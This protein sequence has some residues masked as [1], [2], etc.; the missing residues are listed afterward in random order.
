[1][2][3]LKFDKYIYRE[4][5]I[6]LDIYLF[7]SQ[8]PYSSQGHG[9]TEADQADPLQAQRCSVGTAAPSILTQTPQKK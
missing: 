4:M 1:M 2:Q 6:Y 5:Y 9:G 8:E 7:F 3:V